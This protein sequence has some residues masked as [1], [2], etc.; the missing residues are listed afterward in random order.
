MAAI[1]ALLLLVYKAI[2]RRTFDWKFIACLLGY[3]AIL[4]GAF[5]ALNAI[6]FWFWS[7]LELLPVILLTIHGWYRAAKALGDHSSRPVLGL[8]TADDFGRISFT[9]LRINGFRP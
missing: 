5:S 3:E 7:L 4:I 8:G 1:L 2:T 9:W 6:Q